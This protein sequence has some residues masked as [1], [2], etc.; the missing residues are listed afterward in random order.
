MKSVVKVSHDHSDNGACVQCPADG[1]FKAYHPECARRYKVYLGYGYTS[2]PYWRI[3]CSSHSELPIKTRLK[4]L[5]SDVHTC[6]LKACRGIN[7]FADLYGTPV[8]NEEENGRRVVIK[9]I[10]RP[11]SSLK[12]AKSKQDLIVNAF[13]E[14]FY[15]SVNDNSGPKFAITLR[16]DPEGG[17][18]VDHVS[19][20]H[21]DDQDTVV[22]E[23]SLGKR[24]PIKECIEASKPRNKKKKRS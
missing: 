11:G 3:Y 18:S 10:N 9:R 17:Y 19:I 6:L 8:N 7:R 4:K 5:V 15:Q 13:L 16:R 22:D 2:Y 12:S 24:Q 14:S 1:C 20:P 21:P 23:S